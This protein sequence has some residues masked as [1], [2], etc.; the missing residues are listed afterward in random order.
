MT[1]EQKQLVTQIQYTGKEGHENIK[2]LRS[3]LCVM[4]FLYAGLPI[5]DPHLFTSSEAPKFKPREF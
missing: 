2:H 3:K 4:G 5:N 1:S